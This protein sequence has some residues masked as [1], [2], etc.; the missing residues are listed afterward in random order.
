MSVIS[1]STVSPAP[2]SIPDPKTTNHRLPDRP[3][4]PPHDRQQLHPRRSAASRRRSKRVNTLGW[5]MQRQLGISLSVIVVV[6]A[7]NAASTA[8]LFLSTRWTPAPSYHLRNPFSRFL[9]LSFRLPDSDL[10]YKG[11]DD[12]YFIAWW[13]LVFWFLREALMRW[14]LAPFARRRG[15]KE[16]RNVVRFAEQGWSVFYYVIFWSLGLYIMQTSPYAWLNTREFYV[17]YPHIAISGLTK[18]YYLAQTAFWVQQIIVINLEAKRKDYYQMF[19]HHIITTLLMMLSYIQ[20]WTR[21]G[22]AILCTMDVADILLSSAKLIKY[23]D[24]PQAADV[25]FAVFLVVWI[26]TRH[27]AFGMITY[28]VYA[29]AHQILEY[30]WRP[31]D[32]YFHSW[33]AM[34]IFKFLLTALQA[35][36]VIWLGMILRVVWKMVVVGA[37]AEDIRSD[38]E[39]ESENE[40][41]DQGSETDNEKEC[42]LEEAGEGSR[43]GRDRVLQWAKGGRARQ[44]AVRVEVFECGGR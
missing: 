3:R 5:C 38:D 37:V 19:T 41:D 10:Y 17:G 1:R 6:L 42:E 32:G 16:E 33:W 2:A 29:E 15:I 9:Y 23:C 43:E 27:V 14:V 11:R 22:T 7:V 25:M 39:A 13:V 28:S 35:L 8:E 26:A 44:T 12:A 31:Q 21:I 34:F 24:R 18:F 40:E 20:N 30:D 36:L 4:P